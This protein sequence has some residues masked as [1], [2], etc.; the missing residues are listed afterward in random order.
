MGSTHVEPAS[1]AVCGPPDQHGALGDADA[2]SANKMTTAAPRRIECLLLNLGSLSVS[3]RSENEA[4][5]T[6]E[7][8]PPHAGKYGTGMQACRGFQRWTAD[9]SGD[10]L[11]DSCTPRARDSSRDLQGLPKSHSILELVERTA[12]KTALFHPNQR[13]RESR[14]DDW[15]WDVARLRLTV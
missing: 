2:G 10:N 5:G 8:G 3:A 4:G 9:D 1:G 11:Q 12:D 6:A 13:G 7:I 14:R 15:R